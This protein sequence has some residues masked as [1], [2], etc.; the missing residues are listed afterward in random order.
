MMESQTAGERNDKEPNRQGKGSDGAE[1]DNIILK[2]RQ[3]I[4]EK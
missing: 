1:H 2:R 4:V 3:Y